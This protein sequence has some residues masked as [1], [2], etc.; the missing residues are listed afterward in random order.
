MSSFRSSL[1]TYPSRCVLQRAFRGSSALALE[2]QEGEKPYVSI[3]P[4]VLPRFLKDG[5]IL[6]MGDAS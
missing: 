6:P 3:L 4:P 2:K 1:S 5:S